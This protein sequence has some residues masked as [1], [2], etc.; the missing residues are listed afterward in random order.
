MPRGSLTRERALRQAYAAHSG[1]LYSLAARSLGDAGLAEEAVQETFVLA[2]RGRERFDPEVGTVRTWLF[3]ILRNVVI[4]LGRGRA[5]E[6]GDDDDIAQSVHAWQVEEAM[7]RIGEPYREVLLE[8]YYR[9]RSC[10]ELATELGVPEATVRSR[11]YDGM[12]TLQEALDEVRFE[13]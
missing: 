9:G 6:P 1:E 4:E 12:R 8:T 2:W 5:A 3:A 11:I 10:T 13:G 7:R